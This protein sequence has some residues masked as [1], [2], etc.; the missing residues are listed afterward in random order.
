M[1]GVQ[2]TGVTLA[3]QPRQPQASPV[4]K[5][6]AVIHCIA[7]NSAKIN[8]SQCG[9][10]TQAPGADSST[11]VKFARKRTAAI[12]WLSLLAPTDN[13]IQRIS[14]PLAHRNGAASPHS[15]ARRDDNAIHRT[16]ELDSAC[17]IQFGGLRVCLSLTSMHH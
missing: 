11:P 7:R 10:N 9:I 4:Q 16:S 2:Q 8:A 12:R 17:C 14:P 6:H 5:C 1:I 13:N 15:S 3:A